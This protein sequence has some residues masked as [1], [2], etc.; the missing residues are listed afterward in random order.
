MELKGIRNSF[1]AKR[2]LGAEKRAGR[3]GSSVTESRAKAQRAKLDAQAQA[4]QTQ[5]EQLRATE[6]TQQKKT[7]RQ[8]L[9]ARRRTLEALIEAYLQDHIGGNRSDK[10]VEW[11]R[12]SLGLL[13]SFLEELDIVQI[14][15][16]EAEDI[17][18]WFTH[19]RSAPGMR[20]KVRCE[21]TIQTYARSARAFFHWLVRR[22]FIE[23]NPFDLVL[24]PKVGKP[25]IQTITAD[26]FERL[27]WA[28]APPNETGPI[29]ER[30]AVRNRAILWVFYDAGIRVSELCSL[31]LDSFDRRHGI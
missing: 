3:K 18:A 22:Q 12:I 27:L 1:P 26:E 11:H 16:V 7:A 24:F 8:E 20:G 29:A 15:D 30:A 13:R 14:D 5:Q 23:K 25:L 28:C 6:T 19:L 4:R 17:S 21:R 9:Q 10:T 31:R 2:S